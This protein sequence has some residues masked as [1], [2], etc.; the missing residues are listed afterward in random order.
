[1]D[2]AKGQMKKEGDRMAWTWGFLGFQTGVYDRV[3]G[4]DARNG[5]SPGA[6]ILENAAASN[7]PMDG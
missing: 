3:A 5:Q 1:M 7:L 2:A 4:V 6:T